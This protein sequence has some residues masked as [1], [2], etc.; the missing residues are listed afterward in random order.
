[1]KRQ[2]QAAIGVM[3]VPVAL[4][5]ARV[6]VTDFTREK[7]DVVGRY[8]GVVTING[9]TKKLAEEVAKLTDNWG[10]DVVFEASG[11]PKA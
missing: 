11:S 4:A 6:I 2:R 7:L 3:T 1:M 10:A 5:G 9:K 8:S